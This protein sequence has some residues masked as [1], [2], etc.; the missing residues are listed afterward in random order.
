MGRNRGEDLVRDTRADQCLPAQ[1]DGPTSN[2]SHTPGHR[3]SLTL[4]GT[5]RP[6]VQIPPPRPRKAR[7]E[8]GSLI[9]G[10]GLQHLSLDIR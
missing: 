9:Q 3:A 2:F 6:W 7:S 10:T 1:T 5:K 8:A 4:F